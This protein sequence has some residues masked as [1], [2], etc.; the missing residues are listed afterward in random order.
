VS[1]GLSIRL[2]CPLVEWVDLSRFTEGDA[3]FDEKQLLRAARHPGDGVGWSLEVIERSVAVDD[4]DDLRFRGRLVEVDSANVEIGVSRPKN[5]QILHPGLAD[6]DAA[7]AVDEE[8]RVIADP[9]AYFEDGLYG[10]IEAKRG[11]MLL[12]TLVVTHV[13]RGP[14]DLLEGKHGARILAEVE[15]LAT[16]SRSSW[17]DV[18]VAPTFV[19]ARLD[20][21]EEDLRE[22]GAQVR[23][24]FRPTGA[25][26]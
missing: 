8:A 22:L 2:I 4:I 15:L 17:I 20:P 16:M 18:T 11:E 24:G 6:D 12:P 9:R 5:L 1:I 21:R 25:G 13:V 19:P 23:F 14:E 3:G 7:S 26:A 10:E